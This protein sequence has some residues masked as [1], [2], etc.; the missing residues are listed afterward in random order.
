MRYHSQICEPFPNQFIS[1]TESECN[2]QSSKVFAFKMA[3]MHAGLF[4]DIDTEE[5]FQME[6]ESFI[7]VE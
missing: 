7:E 4:L 6:G 3:K 2:Q 1:I 5:E